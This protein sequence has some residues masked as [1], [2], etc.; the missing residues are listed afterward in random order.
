MSS[1]TLILK[2]IKSIEALASLLASKT[3]SLK[4]EIEVNLKENKEKLNLDID[5]SELGELN[6][7]VSTCRIL[8]KVFIAMI[9]IFQNFQIQSLKLLHMDFLLLV[10]IVKK[11]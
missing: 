7:L 4:E 10:L 6:V 9:L 1:L 5:E 8:K 3:K 2:K 11:I